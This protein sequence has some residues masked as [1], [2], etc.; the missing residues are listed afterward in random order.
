MS[1]AKAKAKAEAKSK[2]KAEAKKKAEAQGAQWAM[3]SVMFSYVFHALKLV[4]TKNLMFNMMIS[5]SSGRWQAKADAKAKAP[6]K[7]QAAGAQPQSTLGGLGVS[8]SLGQ[9]RG[10]SSGRVLERSQREFRENSCQNAQISN[11]VGR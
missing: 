9:E 1:S 4:F 8:T 2:S 11:S 3:V 7:S 10:R 5:M 6:G